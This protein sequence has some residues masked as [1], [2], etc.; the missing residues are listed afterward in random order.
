MMI[1]EDEQAKQA[2]FISSASGNHV[3]KAATLYK[4][5]AVELAGRCIIEGGVVVR[6]DLAA[7]RI[8]KHVRVGTN[9]VLRP[10]YAAVAGGI[11]FVPLSVGRFT[12][13]GRGCLIESAVIGVGCVIE[14][15]CVLSKRC[16]LKDYVLVT[17]GSIVP[18]DAVIPPFAIVSGRPG[19]VVGERPESVTATTEGDIKLR[20]RCFKLS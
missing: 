18:P 6:G 13:I 3:A 20:Y 5:T 9:S 2:D 19:R 14:D 1:V 4:P 16:I 12:S 7:V 15:D 11:R 8:D 17:K 10:S